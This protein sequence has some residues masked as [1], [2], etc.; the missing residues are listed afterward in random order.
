M[1][2]ALQDRPI[3]R[4]FQLQWIVPETPACRRCGDKN[5]SGKD[6]TLK[7]NLRQKVLSEPKF[8]KL[9]KLYE[10]KHVPISTPA[11]F[12]GTSWAEVVKRT[13]NKKT[14]HQPNQKDNHK[15]DNSVEKRLDRME[16]AIN[17]ILNHLKLKETEINLADHQQQATNEDHNPRATPEPKKTTTD[18]GKGPEIDNTPNS[19]LAIIDTITKGGDDPEKKIR[20]L[21]QAFAKYHQE[22]GLRIRHLE[23]NMSDI[24]VKLDR[25]SDMEMETNPDNHQ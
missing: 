2:N 24:L 16:N 9:A 23:D 21:S 6:C 10:W 8:Q 1:N 13:G 25:Y 14:G 5:H 7:P 4:N 12:G 20:S 18:K 15:L 17:L 22:T 11:N 3:F 19:P